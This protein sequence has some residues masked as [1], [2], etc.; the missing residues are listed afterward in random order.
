MS[1][2][3]ETTRCERGEIERNESNNGVKLNNARIVVVILIEVITGSL[4]Y[5][6][7]GGTVFYNTVHS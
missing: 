6:A 4:R 7:F 2:R 3:M 5:E 1:R